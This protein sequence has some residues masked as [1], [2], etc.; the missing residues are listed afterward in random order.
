MSLVHIGEHQY[1]INDINNIEIKRDDNSS[2]IINS[3]LLTQSLDQTHILLNKFKTFPVDVF[4]ILGMRNL[5]SFV[6]ESFSQT[7][8]NINSNIIKNPHQDGYPDLLPLDEFGLKCWNDI[9]DKEEKE[10]F[11]PFTGGGFEIK[12]TCGMIDTP[13]LFAK[14]NLKRP[15][16]KESRINYVKKYDWKAHHQQT[17]NLIG[18]LWDFINETPTILGIFYSNNLDKNDWGNI[19]QPKIHGGKT[20]SVSMMNKS[21]INKMYLGWIL[22]LDSEPLISMI[23]KFNKGDKIGASR[24]RTYEC[25]STSAV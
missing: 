2:S 12:A 6:G 1:L 25:I 3:D 14:K 20:T 4:K 5:S 22:V 11:S 24:I 18:I 23:D 17:N 13:K 8:S 15:K 16:F 9:K 7:L 21:G 10:P 19:V